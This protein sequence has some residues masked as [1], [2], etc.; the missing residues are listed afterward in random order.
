MF[1]SISLTIKNNVIYIFLAFCHPGT[2]KMDAQSMMTLKSFSY[3]KNSN[4]IMFFLL[5]S[6]TKSTTFFEQQRNEKFKNS[7]KSKS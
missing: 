5:H 6:L 4:M 7:E 3:Q 1:I 2:V